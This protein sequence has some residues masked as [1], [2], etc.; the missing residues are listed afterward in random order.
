M[1]TELSA[2]LG[3]AVFVG[4]LMLLCVFVAALAA[5]TMTFQRNLSNSA[6]VTVIGLGV[7]WDSACTSSVTSIAWGSIA[8][9]TSADEYVYI[10]NEGTGTVTISM[11]YGN[12][13]PAA[14][15]PYMTLTWNCSGYSL[16]RSAVAG[17]KFTLTVA[18][19]ATG[20]TDF[21]FSIVLQATA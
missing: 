15:A 10:R 16:A 19:G 8:P 6:T 14:A 1:K 18:S 12:F 5:Q 3:H 2:P 4:T 7:Y 11:T 9:G 13:T 20:I 17:A 21:G